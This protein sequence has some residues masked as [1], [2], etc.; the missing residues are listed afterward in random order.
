MLGVYRAVYGRFIGCLLNSLWTMLSLLSGFWTIYWLFIELTRQAGVPCRVSGG[1][2]TRLREFY[3]VLS[4]LLPAPGFRDSG[5]RDT[6]GGSGK[7]YYV[8]NNGFNW[9]STVT[10]ANAHF[11]NCYYGGIYPNGS[12]NRATGLQLRCLQE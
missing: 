8:G 7:L 10:G 4:T 5:Y 9:S 11:L 2:F 1:P 12:D 6:Q 3:R